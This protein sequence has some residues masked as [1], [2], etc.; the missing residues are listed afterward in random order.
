MCDY[1]FSVCATNAE[2]DN[3]PQLPSCVDGNC[4]GK[5][6]GNIKIDFSST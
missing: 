6:D 2:C 4:V 1:G 3:I 5:L